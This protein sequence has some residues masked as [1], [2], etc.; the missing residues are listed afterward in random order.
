MEYGRFLLEGMKREWVDYY[1]RKKLAGAPEE[2]EPR[3][4]GHSFEGTLSTQ[5]SCTFAERLEASRPNSSSSKQHTRQIEVVNT[6]RPSP[7]SSSPPL[8]ASDSFALPDSLDVPRHRFAPR[9]RSRRPPFDRHASMPDLHP[10]FTA[11]F[12]ADDEEEDER[13]DVTEL[14]LD[15]NL[16]PGDILITSSTCVA[17]RREVTCVV[18]QA[19]GLVNAAPTTPTDILYGDDVSEASE[20]SMKVIVER[21]QSDDY[22]R[23][24]EAVDAAERRELTFLDCMQEDQEAYTITFGSDASMAGDSYSAPSPVKPYNVDAEPEI[25]V[26]CDSSFHTAEDTSSICPQPSDCAVPFEKNDMPLPSPHNP[27]TTDEPSEKSSGLSVVFP[28]YSALEATEMTEGG[29]RQKGVDRV[30]SWFRTPGQVMQCGMV[31]EPVASPEVETGNEVEA[32]RSSDDPSSQPPRLPSHFR[33]K[34]MQLKPLELVRLTQQRTFDDL[35]RNEVNKTGV[36]RRKSLSPLT[37]RVRHGLVTPITPVSSTIL[38]EQHGKV[39]EEVVSPT[40]SDETMESFGEER[41]R[42][43]L[44]RAF[45]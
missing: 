8:P 34:A 4:E 22:A 42:E 31:E 27:P 23:I 13:S 39:R 14:E 12:D 26:D 6:S 24:Q 7:L 41:R 25:A 36:D 16:R 30:V 15:S 43:M 45:L 35:F 18:V 40:G 9:S 11:E 3:F 17:A 1:T 10:V 19:K 21:G 29:K 20:D 44:E 38:D 5:S 33:E 2:G 28:E 32:P 37:S